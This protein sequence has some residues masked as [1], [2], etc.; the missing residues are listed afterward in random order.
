MKVFISWSG[1]RSQAIAEQLSKFLKKVIQSAD[2]FISTAMDAGVKWN[3][4]I[5]QNL[6]E[7]G[8]GILCVTPGNAEK[9]WLN[10]EAGA[11]SRHLD[12]SGRVIPY[13]LDFGSAGNLKPPLSQFNAVTADKPGTF[14]LVQTLNGRCVKPQAADDLAET[15][16]AFWPALAE[17]I[18]KIKATSHQPPARRDP[19]EK[20]DELLSLTHQILR[21]IERQTSD[22]PSPPKVRRFVRGDEDTS[23]I[24]ALWA[25]VTAGDRRQ[26]TAAER[27]RL[28]GRLSA[29][30]TMQRKIVQ[31]T[32]MNEPQVTID[33]VASLLALDIDHVEALR[34]SA[35]TA[36]TRPT[37]GEKPMRP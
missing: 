34:L 36:L 31:L 9:P 10:F 29:L 11:L 12:D 30:P 35:L 7:H 8:I 17:Q 22:D 2:P 1:T 25:V 5:A 37:D 4:V 32:I 14:K 24:E 20:L 23:G 18:T 33:Q 26:L 13:L 16:E 6:D 28:A 15:F 27:Q 3:E 21:Q 19:G